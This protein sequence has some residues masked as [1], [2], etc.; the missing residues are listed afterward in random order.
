MHTTYAPISANDFVKKFLKENPS[1]KEEKIRE[2]LSKAAFH[3]FQGDSC[4]CGNELWVIG[5][6]AVGLSCF[7]CI[8]GNETPSKDYELEEVLEHMKRRTGRHIDTM[9]PSEI[10]GWFDDAGYE[11]DPVETT[12]EACY[13]CLFMYSQDED[14][15]SFCSLKR[16]DQVLYPGEFVCERFRKL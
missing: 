3:F 1:W 7:Q 4:E 10:D 12:P 2:S 13:G 11:L 8:T 6:A 16:L 14:M 15:R 9:E 5:S